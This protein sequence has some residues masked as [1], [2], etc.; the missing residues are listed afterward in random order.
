MGMQREVQ[1]GEDEREKELGRDKVGEVGRRASEHAREVRRVDARLDVPQVDRPGPGLLTKV[2]ALEPCRPRRR[3][4]GGPSVVVDVRVER[5][6]E[7]DRLAAVGLEPPREVQELLGGGGSGRRARVDA[8]VEEEKGK[9]LDLVRLEVDRGRR[10]L[11]VEPV[12]RLQ[13]ERKR[14]EGEP[15][16]ARRDKGQTKS[17]KREESQVDAL[18]FGPE[19]AVVRLPGV[20]ARHLI[21]LEDVLL[22]RP[23]ARVEERLRRGDE[24]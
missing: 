21:D 2:E 17:C 23:A 11:V 19:S 13:N 15:I 24:S 1:V 9:R 5:E 7:V 4:G 20:A 22:P 16:A 3:A 8:E 6:P 18:D 14:H 10:R 12:K